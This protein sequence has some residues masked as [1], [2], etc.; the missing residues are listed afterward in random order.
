MGELT[1]KISPDGSKVDMDADEFV[2]T[3][4]K[5]FAKSIIEALGKV[6]SEKKKDAYFSHQDSGQSVGVK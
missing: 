6:E 5:D 3:G 1:I 2:G 4:C